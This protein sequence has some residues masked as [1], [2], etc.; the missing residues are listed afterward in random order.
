MTQLTATFTVTIKTKPDGDYYF[1]HDDLVRNVV[2]WI[3][4]GL[5]DRDDIAEVTITEQ[6]TE[7]AH[8]ELRHARAALARIRQMADYWEQHLPEV[9]RTPAVVSALR[10]AMERAE[11]AAVSAAVAPPTTTT[12]GLSVQHADALWDAVAIPGPR[13]ATYPEQHERVCRAVREILDELTPAR[14][15]A[16]AQTALRDRIAEALM[17]WAEGNNSPKYT[18]MRRPETVVQNAY[19]RAD[20]VLAV[21]PSSGCLTPEYTDGP[22]HCP[23]CDPAAHRTDRAVVLADVE[24]AIRTATGSCGYKAEDGCDFCNGVDAALD[25]VRRV[26]DETAT[27][28]PPLVHVGWWCWRGG[29]HGHLAAMACRSDNV[30]IHVPAEWEDDMRAV[31][32]RLEDEDDEPAAGA[33][34]DGAHQ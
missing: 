5:D 29:N 11:S 33:R 34:Q 2:P 26:A 12:H 32:Q 13:T 25:Q 30:P 24:R 27:E 22:C 7:E 9:I 14:A 3:E 10:A 4:G 28:T 6:A 19:S 8:A 18:S 16:D 21:L 15:D 1:D 17:Q 31:I 23:A 20:A